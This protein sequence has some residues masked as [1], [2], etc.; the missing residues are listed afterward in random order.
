MVFQSWL[1]ARREDSEPLLYGGSLMT[2]GAYGF[3]FAAF[4]TRSNQTWTWSLE[5]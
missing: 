2:I 3:L 4:Q 5:T 1:L